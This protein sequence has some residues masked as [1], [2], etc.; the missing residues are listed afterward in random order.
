MA[1]PQPWPRAIGQAADELG[2]EQVGRLQSGPTLTGWGGVAER[3]AGS[4]AHG[5]HKKAPPKAGPRMKSGLQSGLGRGA[6][7][8][9]DALAQ[10]TAPTE[11]GSGAEQGQRA[12]DSG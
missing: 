12:W 10:A 2:H 1:W 3:R 8:S 5:G 6:Q 11:G 4:A 7:R 9:G